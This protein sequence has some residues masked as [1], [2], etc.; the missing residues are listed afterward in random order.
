MAMGDVV[1]NLPRRATNYEKVEEI[2]V[3]HIE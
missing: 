2:C 3:S 1:A